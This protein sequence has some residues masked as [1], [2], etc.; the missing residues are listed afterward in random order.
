MSSPALICA[1]RR[2]SAFGVLAETLKKL[3]LLGDK[4]STNTSD[5]QRVMALTPEMAFRQAVLFFTEKEFIAGGETR[6]GH[7]EP[8]FTYMQAG[9]QLLCTV[10]L[11]KPGVWAHSLARILRKLDLEKF[12][13]VGMKHISLKPDIVLGLLSSEAKQEPAILEAHCSYL[14]SGSS[15]VLCLQRQNAVKKL[16]DLLGPEDPTLAQ[17]LDPCFWRAQYGASSVQNGFY[18]SRSYHAAVRDMKLFFPEGLCCAD[19]RVL[20]EEEHS[21]LDG[22]CLVVAAQRDNAIICFESLL[23]SYMHLASSDGS[24][25]PRTWQS[26]RMRVI[27]QHNRP[28]H[29]CA[30]DNTIRIL[31]LLNGH[32]RML[33]NYQIFK[34]TLA[35]ELLC[36]LFD[37]LTS[38]SF[39]RIETLD[40]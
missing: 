1:L 8:L 26:P 25:V 30:V 12:S 9:A 33:E 24:V 4:T 31:L 29:R 10:L 7:A 36:C 2:V 38:N 28:I 35:E 22:A 27:T 5:L 39:F 17:T 11:I 15:L 16:V 21:L 19:S 23:D 32:T 6:R 13:L 37:S 14:T 34:N 18:G 40:A 3:T 20:K